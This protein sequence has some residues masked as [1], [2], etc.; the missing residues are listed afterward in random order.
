MIA[1]IAF[2]TRHGST[3]GVADRLGRGLRSSGI[4]AE[5]RPVAELT[6]LAGYDAVVLGS[7]VHNGRWLPEAR[8]FALRNAA[9]L[10]ERPTWLF[11]V[12][13]LGDQESMIAPAVA[14]ALRA[15]RTETPEVTAL[16]SAIHP[17]EHRNFA[18]AIARG[19]WSRA[20]DVFLRVLGGHHGD[21]RNWPAI[22][23]W[24]AD[25]AAR[26]TTASTGPG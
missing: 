20:G 24:A 14:R 25:I 17:R 5:V 10:R 18:G 21:H 23:A 11:S 15:L 12:G 6:D 1:L 22:D 26:L 16:R 9:T 2:A 3:E 19:D 13:T 4:A 8:E 7:A